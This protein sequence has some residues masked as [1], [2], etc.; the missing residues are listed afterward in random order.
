MSRC[1]GT[2]TQCCSFRMPSSAFAVPLAT[3]PTAFQPANLYA[4][5]VP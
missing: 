1:R 3:T 2:A 4:A 5:P